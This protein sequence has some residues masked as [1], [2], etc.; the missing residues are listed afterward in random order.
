MMQLV[1][2]LLFCECKDKNRFK[3]PHRQDKSGL[4]WTT[5]GWAHMGY[6]RLGWAR[7]G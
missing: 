3:V 1:M 4:G 7:L 2:W 6:A 5:L